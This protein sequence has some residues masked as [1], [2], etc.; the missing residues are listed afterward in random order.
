MGYPRPSAPSPSPFSGH[1][2]GSPSARW[3]RR[4]GG[5]S[6]YTDLAP[7]ANLGSCRDHARR[8]RPRFCWLAALRLAGDGPLSGHD[9]RWGA[10]AAASVASSCPPSPSPG[11]SAP[12][13]PSLGGAFIGGGVLVS[14]PP[15]APRKRAAARSPRAPARPHAL[16]SHPRPSSFSPASSARS[17]EAVRAP[18]IRLGAFGR[19][20]GRFEPLYH[21]GT[22]LPPALG[23]SAASPGGS[24]PARDAVGP[25]LER[26]LPVALALLAM[27]SLSPRH[28][29]RRARHRP[30][31]RRRRPRKPPGRWPPRCWVSRAPRHRG[32][33]P[34][35]HPLHQNLQ[36]ATAGCPLGTCP[37]GR[38]GPA[39]QGFGSAIG[40]VIAP[41]Q[42]HRGFRHRGPVTAKERPR[43]SART[44]A[45]AGGARG[46]GGVYTCSRRRPRP[47]PRASAVS[48]PMT[49]ADLAHCPRPSLDEGDPRR[50]SCH[51]ADTLADATG[52]RRAVRA[53]GDAARGR[54]GRP[55]GAV[56]VSSPTREM[57]SALPRA[58]RQS[59]RPPAHCPR[60]AS[61][62]PPARH[63][64]RHFAPLARNFAP[65]FS[66]SYLIATIFSKAAPHG[67][68]RPF[69]P[70]KF[71]RRHPLDRRHPR[72]DGL[73]FRARGSR[74]QVRAPSSPC[75]RGR[76]RS[77]ST[78]GNC[79]DVFTPGLYML[80]TNN[81]P[82]LTTLNHWDHGFRSP[83]SPRSTSSPPTASPTT[84]GHQE[85]PVMYGATTEFG[86][87]SACAPSEPYYGE[88]SPTPR[89]SSPRS[90]APNGEF[91][92]DEVTFQ[93]RN[94][95]VQ[96]FSGFV[97]A[98]AQS[99]IPVLRHGREHRR[100]PASSCRGSIGPVI[101]AYGLTLPELYIENISLPP[102]V[103][104]ALVRAHLSGHRGQSRRPPEMEGRRGDGERAARRAMRWRG[105]RRGARHADGRD[106]IGRV[107]GPLGL[108]RPW[109][110]FGVFGG[111]LNRRTLAPMAPAAVGGKHVWHIAKG[112]ETSGPFSKPISAGVVGDWLRSTSARPMS[113]NCGTRRLKDR[114]QGARNWP[115]SSP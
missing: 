30:R 84:S 47:R 97:R 42:H 40:N 104:K 99:G 54:R 78:R 34:P 45:V 53:R 67:H 79:A 69:S 56:G 91:T 23:I 6:T 4:P 86:N 63:A 74:D 70:A 82:V 2:A 90:S 80:E 13:C 16:S 24:G 15:G 51:L 100:C 59:P 105:P 50:L 14:A 83:S 1:A 81:M 94:I 57:P 61:R 38:H 115:S 8:R 5:R 72:H 37:R 3:A 28:G 64:L 12:N 44:L 102:A 107:G 58:P 77:S 17:T 92:S 113:W 109:L 39:A 114:R 76:R 31:R 95:I 108:S 65:R 22:L 48:P 52:R 60:R 85:T 9:L 103:E 66:A 32:R 25:A 33:P 93:I 88:S 68:S 10:L 71:I 106:E 73:A 101:A 21:P 11:S 41:P 75:A 89:S 96:E 55:G 111:F 110:W 87:R 43:S 7:T 20:E 29:P 26:L 98:I 62:S 35:E 112:G 18:A 36:T 49:A 46:G 19:L 27:I